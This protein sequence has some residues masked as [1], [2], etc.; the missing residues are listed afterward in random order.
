MAGKWS[1]AQEG[2]QIVRWKF[3]QHL[4]TAK[5]TECRKEM[6]YLSF[7]MAGKLN[8]GLGFIDLMG[9]TCVFLRLFANQN[10]WK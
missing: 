5:R 1:A 10:D 7:T 2:N 6:K 8:T 4:L 9:Y 3:G